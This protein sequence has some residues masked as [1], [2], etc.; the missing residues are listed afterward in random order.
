MTRPDFTHLPPRQG[1]LALKLEARQAMFGRADVLPLWVADMDFAAP[2]CVRQALIARAEH[3]IYGYTVRDPD[4]LP[5]LCDWI[6]RR[7]GWQPAPAHACIAPGVVPSLYAAVAAF[8]A[9]G[10]GVIVQTPIYPPFLQA[11]Q[12]QGRRLLD[13]PLRCQDGAYSLDL[14]HFEQCARQ[15]RLFLLC[16]PHNPVGRVWS[17]AELQALLAICARHDV[18]VFADEIHADL[19]YPGE[20]HQPALPLAPERVVAAWAPSKTFNIPGMG[21][22][23]LFSEQAALMQRLQAIF[24]AL[25]VS[26]QHPFG[27]VAWTTAY[28]QAEP[29]LEAL[30]Q[31]LQGHRQHVLARLHSELPRLRMSVPQATYL[32]WLDFQ[33]W[34]CSE[35]ELVRRLVDEAGLGLNPGSSFGESG[36]GWMRLNMATTRTQLDLALDRLIAAFA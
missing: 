11:V 3:P 1:T 9:P 22:S 29:W 27:Q 12:T 34:G 14:E 18:I 23:A 33:A 13:N 2:D 25:P 6:G 8:S 7:H 16:S 31:T 5:A 20:V 10:E 17:R 30:L 26:T 21:L 4:M 32:L 28:R 35:P 36:R 15:A 24:A 19:L